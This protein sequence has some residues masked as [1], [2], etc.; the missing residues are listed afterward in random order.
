MMKKIGRITLSILAGSIIAIATWALPQQAANGA[1]QT[2]ASQ[3]QIGLQSASGT[4]VAVKSDSFTLR[5]AADNPQVQRFMP[6]PV[7]KEMIFLIDN[8]T[9]VNGRMTVGATA[10]VIYRE[11]NGKDLAVTV[12]V[13]E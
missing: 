9:T 2:T 11:A 13:D 3:D 7:P 4:I 5:T 1:P 6:A 12:I 10:S 8:N